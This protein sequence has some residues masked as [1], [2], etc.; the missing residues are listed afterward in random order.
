LVELRREI[1]DSYSEAADYGNFAIA[2]INLGHKT[3]ARE[4]ARKARSI[5]EKINIPSLVEMMDKVI[6]EAEA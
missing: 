2:L 4:Y 5:F 6:K 3:E 1:G